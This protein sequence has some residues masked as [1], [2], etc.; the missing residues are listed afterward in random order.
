MLTFEEQRY[1]VEFNL[2]S[3]YNRRQLGRLAHSL[4]S[5]VLDIGSQTG[6]NAALFKD[7]Q[8]FA[9]D[10]GFTSEAKKLRPEIHFATANAAAIPFR[11]GLFDV[12]IINH[13]LE[14]VDQEDAVLKE[15]NRVLKPGGT[16]WLACPT[17]WTGKLRPGER[18]KHGHVRGYTR[19]SLKQTAVRHFNV[20]ATYTT[21]RALWFYHYW[22]LP[23]LGYVNRLQMKLSGDGRL[24]WQRGWM[25]KFMTPLLEMLLFPLED[26]LAPLPWWPTDFLMIQNTSL[27]LNNKNE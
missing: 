15:T 7:C 19:N 18:E 17:G 16:V 3:K 12:V 23:V 4:G 6:D 1:E 14:H 13:V 10:L 27:V 24:I 22:V 11:N 9:F 5:R 2:G 25:I 26:L 20:R 8:L 21:G